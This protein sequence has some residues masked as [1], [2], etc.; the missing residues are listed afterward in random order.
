[1]TFRAFRF[2]A[3]GLA[4]ALLPAVPAHAAAVSAAPERTPTFNG[5]VWA[6]AYDGDT[7]YVGG[8]FTA[9]VVSG[10]SVARTRLAAFDARNGTLRGWAPSAD[11]RVRAIAVSGGAVYVAGEF[12]YVSGVRR[13]SL[14]RLDPVSGAVRSGLAHSVSG[15]PYA[16]SASGGRLYAGGTISAVDGQARS[17]LAAFDLGSGA[18]DGSWRP[19]AN[20]TVQ[21]VVAAGERVYVGGKF[22]AVDG[23]SGSA[24]LAAVHP[25]SGAVDLSFRSTAVD[26]VRALAVSGSTVY[27]AHGGPGGRVVAYAPDGSGRWN[28]TMD[29][30]P[31]AITVLADV[32]YFGG[33][34]DNVCR[35][36]RTGAKGSCLDGSIKRVKLGAAATSDGGLLSWTANGNGSAGVHALAAST[37]LAKVGAGGA[38][39]KIN[40]AAQPYFAQ[41][42]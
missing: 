38:F 31:Q 41:F 19:A 28:L 1:M 26:E 42:S 34:F 4:V 25:S 40:G 36:P 21:A 14:A 30:D 20:G 15:Q 24:R 17:R 3:L 9:A 10:R 2:G 22:G 13:D 32:V 12:G 23:V 6:T 35:S 39:T 33:H 7:V 8:D 5:V 11:G 37:R 16:L 18:L 27:V 29:G